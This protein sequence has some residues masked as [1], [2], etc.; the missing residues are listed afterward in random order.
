MQRVH[1]IV[2]ASNGLAARFDS[3]FRLLCL[4]GRATRRSGTHS[5]TDH[6]AA[7]AEAKTDAC[8]GT[9]N[10]QPNIHKHQTTGS[11][12]K[13]ITKGKDPT[14]CLQTSNDGIRRKEITKGQ[15]SNQILTNIKQQY[16]LCSTSLLHAAS[17]LLMTYPGL[18]GHIFWLVSN[19]CNDVLTLCPVM[20]HSGFSLHFRSLPTN[21][22]II[23]LSCKN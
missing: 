20:D 4:A 1:T 7:P 3:L 15:T 12:A 17:A 9:E 14:K 23:K 19:G 8:W 16:Y 6:P 13:E 18:R 10:I 11:V 5:A 21:K 22:L 2:L